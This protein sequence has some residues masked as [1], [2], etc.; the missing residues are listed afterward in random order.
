MTI[1]LPPYSDELRV[2]V[3]PARAEVVVVPAGELDLHTL[4]PVTGLLTIGDGA[5][6][7]PEVDLSGYWLDGD[8]LHVGRVTIGPGATVGSRSTLL[9]GARVGRGAEVLAGSVRPR[10]QGA[11]VA[12][13]AAADAF[14][15]GADV[16]TDDRAPVDQLLTPRR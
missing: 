3:V 16:L 2:D 7:E 11:E 8:E 15:G 6:V 14:I 13:G 4:P 5:S 12:T 1:D 10:A 9:P